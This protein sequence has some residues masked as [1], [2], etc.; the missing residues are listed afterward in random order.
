MYEVVLKV[1]NYPVLPQLL[2]LDPI[3]EEICTHSVKA[4][5]SLIFCCSYENVLDLYKTTA[6]EL[7]RSS[8]YISAP[9]S[10]KKLICRVCESTMHAFNWRFGRILLHHLLIQKELRHEI[11][12]YLSRV[13]CCYSAT[14]KNILQGNSTVLSLMQQLLQT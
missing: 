9:L 8:L 14:L 5:R 2:T 7:K 3:T 12:L 4:K 1:P 13:Y 11:V 6:P 10:M